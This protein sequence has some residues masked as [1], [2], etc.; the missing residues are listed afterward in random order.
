MCD[1]RAPDYIVMKQKSA[2]S[3]ILG[4]L[5]VGVPVVLGLAACD[6]VYQADPPL[7][8]RSTPAGLQVLVCEPIETDYLSVSTRLLSAEDSDWKGIWEPLLP[9]SIA[10]GSV[11]DSTVLGDPLVSDDLT[12]GAW[13]S[14]FMRGEDKTLNALFIV[15]ELGLDSVQWLRTNG[16]LMHDPCPKGIWPP[17]AEGTPA[18]A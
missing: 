1:R 11:L 10:G 12:P 16:E 4:A 15:P 5:L 17:R 9:M 8:I 7:L 13:V 18:N 3:R 2:L 6:P 14:V